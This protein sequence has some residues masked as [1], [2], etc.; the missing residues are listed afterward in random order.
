MGGTLKADGS[1]SIVGRWT[2]AHE[3]D[4]DGARVFVGPGVRLG[5]SRGRRVLELAADGRFTDHSP[6]A[7]DRSVATRGRWTLEGG[8]LRLRYT[9]G[10]EQRYRCQV[11]TDGTL[12]LRSP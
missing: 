11:A 7:A 12:E 6:G 5:L 9:D 3:R 10:R 4:H 8:D 2:H 1:G